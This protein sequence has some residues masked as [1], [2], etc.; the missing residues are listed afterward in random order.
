[1]D[2]AELAGVVE[3]FDRIDE[4]RPQHIADLSRHVLVVDVAL[5]TG[6]RERVSNFGRNHVQRCLV[7]GE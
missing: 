1:M 2:R 6:L 5:A 3:R 4:Q 7:S